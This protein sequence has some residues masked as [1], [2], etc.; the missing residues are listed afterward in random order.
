V[1]EIDWRTY[2]ASFHDER[3]GITEQVLDH[4]RD[5]AGQ[6][7]Y[8][9]AAAAVP[10]DALVVDLACGSGPMAHHLDTRRYVGLDL[11]LAELR[12]ARAKPLAIAQADARRLPLRDST[13]DAV[14]M[15]MALMLV[16]LKE[17]LAEVKRVLRPGG[18]FVATLPHNRPMPP[19]DWLRYARLCLALRHPG[20]SYPSSRSLADAAAAFES[21]GLTL[22]EDD[23]RAFACRIADSDVA[24]QLLASLYLPDVAE[25]RM[26]S[27]RKVVRK[28][29]G[30]DLTTPMRRFVASG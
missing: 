13:A 30:T 27:G 20:L 23:E 14:V 22:Q 6:T 18:I 16:P 8:D 7:P 15:S 3:A 24:D 12:A 29:I 2:L 17:T 10:A 19:G 25:D 5:E 11:S 1:S 26:R 4:A 28:W 21:A 9:W